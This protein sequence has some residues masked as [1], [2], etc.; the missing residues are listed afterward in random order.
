MD[1]TSEEVILGE[2]VPLDHF[3]SGSS[4]C[5]LELFINYVKQSHIKSLNKQNPYKLLQ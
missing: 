1:V 2:C 5:T 4:H 3:S